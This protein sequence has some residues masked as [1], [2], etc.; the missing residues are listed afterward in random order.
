[1]S[2]IITA[3]VFLVEAGEA[4]FRIDDARV[5]ATAGDLLIAPAGSAHCFTST[6]GNELRLT[7]IHAAATMETEWLGSARKARPRMADGATD[8]H[9][10]HRANGAPC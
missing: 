8:V 9:A 3:E 10:D 7:A 5:E 6:A 1:M 4:D 2:L